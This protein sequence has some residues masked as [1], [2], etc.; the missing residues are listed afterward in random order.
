MQFEF[1]GCNID[2]WTHFQDFYYFFRDA[3]FRLYRLGPKGLDLIERY[4]EL[5]EAF[6]TTNYFAQRL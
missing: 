2:S 3:G 6:T 1:G 4:S 5:D